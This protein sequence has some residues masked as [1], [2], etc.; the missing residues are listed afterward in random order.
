M[1]TQKPAQEQ[2]PRVH[3]ELRQALE[4]TRNGERLQQRRALA[5]QAEDR[6]RTALERARATL[7]TEQADVQ[8]LESYSPTRI[9]A[10]LCGSRDTDLARERAEQDAAEYA[11]AR[12]EADLAE[13]RRETSRL[14]AAATALG[15]VASRRARALRAVEDWVRATGS[16]VAAELDRVAHDLASARSAATEVREAVLAAD[17]AATRLETVRRTLGSAG[18]WAAYDTFLGGGLV[19][20]MVKYDRMDQAQRELRDADESLRHL[21]VELAGVGSGAVV[22]PLNVDGFTRTFDVWF[23]NVF[24]DW[25][26]R[27]R[28]SEAVAQVDAA[29]DAVDRLRRDLRDRERA[30]AVQQESLVAERDRVLTDASGS[31]G[32]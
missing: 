7:V 22:G 31:T 10:A 17:L 9:W 28:I 32:G 14:E 19:G 18:D 11:V 4:D 8:A 29:A 25:S 16:T 26:V 12:A 15:D 3:D 2:G 6:A 24:S 21:A 30:L 27:S 23:D 13:A 20:D 5:G 1:T